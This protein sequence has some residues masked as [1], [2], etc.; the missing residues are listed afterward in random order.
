MSQ[1]KLPWEPNWVPPGAD[2]NLINE[3]TNLAR[4][5]TGAITNVAEHVVPG[6]APAIND[7]G[8]IIQAGEAAAGAAVGS[9][10]AGTPGGGVNWSGAVEAAAGAAVQVAIP[11]IQKRVASAAAN[12]LQDELDKLGGAPIPQ[13]PVKD[14]KK[15]DAWERAGRTFLAGIA[16]TILG[17]IVQVIGQASA[18]GVD[19]FHKDGWVAVGTLFVA[20]LITS[21]SSYLLRIISEPAG[22]AVDSSAK[23]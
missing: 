13:I 7:V 9:V 5:A 20:A 1:P 17:V 22:A 6:A 19:F 16:V 12:A 3:V 15:V 8:T 18:T 2:Q 4:G 11:V 21:I 14:L 23:T 10:A